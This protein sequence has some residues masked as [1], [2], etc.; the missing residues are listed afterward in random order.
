VFCYCNGVSCDCYF[1]VAIKFSDSLPMK[2]SLRS[3]NKYPQR[4]RKYPQRTRNTPRG[5][6]TPQKTQN[7]PEASKPPRGLKT[8][9]GVGG[10]GGGRGC[11]CGNTDCIYGFIQVYARSKDPCKPETAFSRHHGVAT[12]GGESI[13]LLRDNLNISL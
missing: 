13:P 2:C 3:C 7:P 11:V 5:L 1:T 12:F 4:A 8:P 10:G 6:K 9:Q